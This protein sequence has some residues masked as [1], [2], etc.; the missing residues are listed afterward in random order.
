MEKSIGDLEE[1]EKQARAE[2]ALLFSLLEDPR[3]INVLV[4]RYVELKN[5]DEIA[6]EFSFSKQHIF[7]LHKAGLEEAEKI[8]RKEESTMRQ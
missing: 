6:L 7:R 2:V 4:R 3:Y 1:L 8:Y 5:F